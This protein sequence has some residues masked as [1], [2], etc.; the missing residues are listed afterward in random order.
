MLTQMPDLIQR[1]AS[2]NEEVRTSSIPKKA[3]KAEKDLTYRDRPNG[4]SGS[5]LQLEDLAKGEELQ[6]LLDE[7]HVPIPTQWVEVDRNA[8]KKRDGGPVIAPDLKSR[9]VGRGDLEG[10]DGLRKDSHT[11]DIECHNLLFSYAASE[12]LDLWTADISNAYFQGEELDRLL[13]LEPPPGGLPDPDYADGETM[14]LARVPIYGTEDAGRKFWTRLR[15][16]IVANKFREGK[17]A[18]GDVHH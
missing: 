18:K 11:A 2:W 10:L 6:K 3:K 14:I 17:I 8:F 16:T 7:G 13:L 12:G 4:S 1:M 5:N 9:L 15:K